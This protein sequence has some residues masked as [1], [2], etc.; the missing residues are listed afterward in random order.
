MR[1]IAEYS[2]TPL[3]QAGAEEIAGWRYPEPFS[4]YDWTEDA[5][6]L[7]E[8]LDPSLRGD[9]YYAAED[10]SG[11]L[12]G[13]FSF[14]REDPQVVKIGL[15]LRPDRT[16]L[17]LGST[18][19]EAGLA[20]ARSRF[21]PAEFVLAVATFNTRAMTVYERVGF[22]PSRV[23]MHWTNGGEWEFVEMRRPA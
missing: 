8:L 7:A 17:G 15:G 22:R 16:G 4:F 14:R 1:A 11:E 19:L 9:S 20:Y 21:Q 10:E 18:F 23:F 6:D 12:I 2:F 3:T 5:D 13:Y